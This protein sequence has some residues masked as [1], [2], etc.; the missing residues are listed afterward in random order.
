[1]NTSRRI[2]PASVWDCSHPLLRIMIQRKRN[3]PTG[4][5][6]RKRNRN[7]SEVS[8]YNQIFINHQNSNYYELFRFYLR[9]QSLFVREIRLQKLLFRY[10]Q[11]Q[12]YLYF[13]SCRRN[14]FIHPFLG[15]QLWRRSLPRLEHHHCA[16]QLQ[17]KPTRKSERPCQILQ[18][19]RPAL[20][21]QV[22]LYRG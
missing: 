17:T 15:I 16:Q 12:R 21:L 9:F 1:M 14:G 6:R 7:A 20:W 13:C 5:K 2:I 18:G 22:P 10:A 11:R 19:I 4:L 3:R 8:V